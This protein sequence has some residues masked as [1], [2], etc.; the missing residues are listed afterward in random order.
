M[1]FWDKIQ[2]D[3][4]KNLQEGIE[5]FKEGSSV[6]TEKIE[7][8]TGEGKKKYHIFNLNM[9]VQEEFA[10]LGGAIYDLTVKKSKNPISNMKIKSILAKIN[11]METQ[12][13]KL[14]GKENNKPAQKAVK[15]RTTKKKAATK[16]KTAAKTKKS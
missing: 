10:K 11:K 14:E 4:K 6:F 5:I 15:K 8:L 9:K 2:D 13:N 1:S 7:E 16:K 3:L 12:I